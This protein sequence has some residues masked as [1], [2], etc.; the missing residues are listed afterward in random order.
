M[1]GRSLVVGSLD[2]EC[3]WIFTQFYSQT[4]DLRLLTH[5]TVMSPY[6]QNGIFSSSIK[7]QHLSH[8]C[9]D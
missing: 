6:L 1:V 5:L 2:S 8:S 4:C 7:T 3:V 9:E